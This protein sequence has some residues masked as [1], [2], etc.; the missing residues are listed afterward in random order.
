MVWQ[1]SLTRLLHVLGNYILSLQC[2]EKLVDTALFNNLHVPLPFTCSEIRQLLDETYL[3][4]K[5]S[6]S[7]SDD[8]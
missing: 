6:Y 3:Y 4:G 8:T 7:E 5:L 2:L 1:V